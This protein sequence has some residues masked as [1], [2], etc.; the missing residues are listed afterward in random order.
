MQTYLPA[1]VHTSMELLA[2]LSEDPTAWGVS[3]AFILLAPALEAA[4]VPWCGVVGQWFSDAPIPPIKKEKS[5]TQRIKIAA[6]MPT[7][8]VGTVATRRKVNHNSRPRA[9]LE[10]IAEVDSNTPFATRQGLASITPF[11]N[12]IPTTP[13]T[14]SSVSLAF[15]VSSAAPSPKIYRSLNSWRRSGA[16]PN[17]STTSLGE[18]A[19][20]VKPLRERM[21]SFAVPGMNGKVPLVRDLAIQPTQRVMRYVLQYGGTS[22]TLRGKVMLLTDM[23]R[24]T[25][26]HAEN[27]RQLPHCG[28]GSR[29][30]PRP[31][32]Q[33]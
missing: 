21:D 2:A 30:R 25:Q 14:P 13:V 5:S 28:S 20:S 33:V 3:M 23:L 19:E 16:T 8:P 26:L 15:P 24:L 29:H 22:L 9:S 18:T 32:S 27:V 11:T 4:F 17:T 10:F 1:L 6:S 31:C 7:T 12:N